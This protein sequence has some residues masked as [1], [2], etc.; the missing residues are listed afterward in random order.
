MEQR[1]Y[2]RIEKK[3]FLVTHTTGNFIDLIRFFRSINRICRK[4]F[5]LSLFYCRRTY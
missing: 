3:E 1:K 5:I 4:M 2:K